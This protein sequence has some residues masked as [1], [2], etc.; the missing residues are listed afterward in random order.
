MMPA[1]KV[2]KN[3]EMQTSFENGLRNGGGKVYY[4][5]RSGKINIFFSEEEQMEIPVAYFDGLAEALVSL[6]VAIQREGK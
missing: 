1:V 2:A 5:Q 6:S 4:Y 3:I